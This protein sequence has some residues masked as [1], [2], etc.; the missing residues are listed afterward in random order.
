MPIQSV[1]PYNNQVLKTFEEFS[2]EKVD[3]LIGQAFEAYQT[4][5]KTSYAKR[6][7]LLRRVAQEMRSKRDDLARLVSLEMGK[8]F[9]EGKGELALSAKIVEYYAENGEKFL[10]PQ[11]L[12]VKYGE[13]EVRYEPIGPL[14]GVMPWNFPYYQVVR[15]AA[16]NI[17]A[18]NSVLIKHASNVPQVSIAIEELFK[19]AGSPPGLYTNLL[20]KSSRVERVIDDDRIAGVSITGSVEAGRHVAKRAGEKLKKVVLELGG[21]DPF[22]ILDDA[23]IPKAVDYAVFSRML[24]SGQQCTAAKR[25]IVE[26]SVSD[27]FLSA[28]SEKLKALVPGDPLDEKTTLAP[29]S[30]EEQ[31][32]KLLSQIDLAVRSGAKV[33]MGGKRL[34]SAGAFV[35]PTIL[36]NI[37]KNSTAYK[38][39]FFGPVALYFQVKNDEEAIHLANDSPF[40]L[41]AAIFTQSPDRAKRIANEIESGMVFVNHPVLSSPELPF[42]GVKNSGFGR[43]LS[44]LGITEFTNKKLVR[45]ASVNDPL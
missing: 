35:E 44:S 8:R 11:K 6:S 2:D 43:E 33:L 7:E 31:A 39:E 13:A 40:G 4:W 26:E 14:L 12:Q 36:T 22:I 10:A 34:Q 28:F 45:L 9:G 38:E 3:Q 1:N 42:G 17:M 29:V 37:E 23:D 15:F 21:S 19:A 5:R 24:N 18:G 16:P 25:F 20:L 41:G 30:S 32:Q 27:K